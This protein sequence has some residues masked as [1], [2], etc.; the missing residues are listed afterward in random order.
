MIARLRL[1]LLLARPPV[2]I[3]LAMFTATGLAEAGRPEAPALLA[4]ALIA[5]AGFLLFSVAC[6]DLADEA[7]DRVNLPGRRPL[8]AGLVTRPT[9]VVIGLTAGAVALAASAALRWQAMVVTG[10]GL[11]VSAGYSLRPVRLADRGAV[12]SLVLPAGYVAVPYA[13]G[14]LAARPGLRPA[15]AFLLGGLYLGFI[16][17][18][19]LK[20][21]RDVRGD[22]LFGKRTFLVRHG[23]RRTCLVS[24]CCWVAGTAAILAAT[25][26][27]T[28][29]L[30]LAEAGCT[31]AALGL[32]AALARS[33]SA[34]RDE[35][36]I[37]AVAIV[38]R[39]MILL[40]LAHLSMIA[41]GWPPLAYGAVTAA[42]CLLIAGP[43]LSMARH[44]PVSRLTVPAWD[45]GTYP[46]GRPASAGRPA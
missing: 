34:R 21:F 16:G 14:V 5:V 42:L 27:P 18:I 30:A 31:A 15:D 24:A 19:L 28:A 44:G 37:A 22:A 23:R 46:A 3:L 35:A 29:L 43:A 11:A 17:R 39:G 36:L 6:N 33:R 40:L 13:D 38:G 26:H 12:A 8:T 32:L 1:I 4:R 25:R 2:L 41:A 45:A 9:F 7:I 20:D 10:A